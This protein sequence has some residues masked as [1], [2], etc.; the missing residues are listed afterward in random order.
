MHQAP[1]RVRDRLFPVRNR[2]LRAAN[3]RSNKSREGAGSGRSMFHK[4]PVPVSGI[5]DSESGGG[6]A[7]HGQRNRFHRIT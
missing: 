2:Q 3:V 1:W 6:M 5:E 7:R 4:M